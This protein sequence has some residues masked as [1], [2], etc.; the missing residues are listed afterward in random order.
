MEAANRTLLDFFLIFLAGGIRSQVEPIGP[1][2]GSLETAAAYSAAFHRRDGR[3]LRRSSALLDEWLVIVSSV[4]MVLRRR[5]QTYQPMNA[6]VHWTGRGSC[7][8]ADMW[9]QRASAH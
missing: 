9:L 6:G 5:R 7:M 1:I 8:G 2:K 3:A 4:R